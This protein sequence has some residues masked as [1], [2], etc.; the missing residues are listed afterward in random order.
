MITV[1]TTINATLSHVWDCFTK[2]EHIVPGTLLLM[3]GTVQQQLPTLKKGQFSY[4]MSIK[5]ARRN[6][7]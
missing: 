7:I 1:Q 6:L 3:I 5:I 2:P 4:T